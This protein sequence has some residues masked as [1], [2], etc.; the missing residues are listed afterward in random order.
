M[1]EQ[2][3]LLEHLLEDFQHGL[4]SLPRQ[5]RAS[6]D[7]H[8]VT[9]FE[10]R[11][12]ESQGFAQLS[13]CTVTYDGIPQLFRGNHPIAVVTAIV[14]YVAHGAKGMPSGFS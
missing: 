2:M 8:I 9:L 4:V 6:Y 3:G 11:V 12:A 14:G 5:F 1:L 13:S 10:I 7:D